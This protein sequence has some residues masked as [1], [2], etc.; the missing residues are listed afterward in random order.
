MAR[1][2]VG[3]CGAGTIAAVHATCTVE[4]GL[5]SVAVASRTAQRAGHMAAT[6]GAEAVTYDQL[7][8]KTDLVVVAT[9]PHRHA[10]D[11][12]R[13]LDAGAAVLLEKPMC[14][15]LVEADA[16]VAAAAAHPGRLLYAENLAYAPVVQQA[17]SMVPR[18][19]RL[20]HVEVRALQALPTWGGFTSDEWG[21]GAL[22]DL[23]VHPLAVALLATNAAGLGRP[24]A[25]SAR[26]KGGAGHNSDEHAEVWLHH[27]RGVVSHVVASWKHPDGPTWD[28]QVSGEHGVVRADLQPSIAL[29][30]NGEPVHVA[31]RA[32][33]VASLDALG[34]ADLG[35]VGQLA[36][37]AD[38]WRT[39][40][41]P[42]MTAA[43][44]RE[45]LQVV[46]A[47]Y[48]SAGRDGVEVALPYTGQRD[49]TPLQTLHGG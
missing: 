14:R 25:V 10:A 13:F 1:P 28:A 15:T 40:S 4:L 33:R 3:L 49:L 12:L 48:A 32:A 8:G 27:R 29:E 23:G 2:T 45:V 47:A 44:G 18:L 7:A 21:G 41:Q 5:P 9:P 37:L 20:T 30:W 43:F 34:L 19:G 17:V 38:C 46:M 22:F 11:A 39:G 16:L 31:R 24:L 6:F 42:L 26:M 35:Y 36:D